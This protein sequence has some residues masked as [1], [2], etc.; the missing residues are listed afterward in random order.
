MIPHSD[1][2]PA[3]ESPAATLVT[4]LLTDNPLSPTG[5]DAVSAFR[6]RRP[7]LFFTVELGGL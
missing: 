2:V 3:G 1:G 4:L 6:P 5:R 7:L